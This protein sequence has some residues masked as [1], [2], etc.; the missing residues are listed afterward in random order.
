MTTTYNV[1]NATNQFI[2][3]EMENELP[4][5]TL[6][7]DIK[8]SEHVTQFQDDPCWD[9]NVWNTEEGKWWDEVW[10]EDCDEENES[11]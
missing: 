7:E 8:D 4:F 6:L 10:T 9:K 11:Q 2:Q 5:L 1:M 3:Q